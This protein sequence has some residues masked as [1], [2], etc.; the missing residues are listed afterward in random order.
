MTTKKVSEEYNRSLE[1]V[2]KRSTPCLNLLT[3]AE[4]TQA[5]TSSSRAQVL[6]LRAKLHAQNQKQNLA[7]RDIKEALS[8]APQNGDI[9]SAI[10]SLQ[11]MLLSE[12]IEDPEELVEEFLNGDRNAGEL[13]AKA[14]SSEKFAK[15]FID[16]NSL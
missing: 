13:L 8:L 2:N 1:D 16:G 5:T 6:T 9:T 3:S 4:L 14:I 10:R 12:P 15:Q 11:S 7:F